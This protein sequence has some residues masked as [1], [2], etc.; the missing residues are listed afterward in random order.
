MFRSVW[1]TALVS[2][3]GQHAR[4]EPLSTSVSCFICE[5]LLVNFVNCVIL[6]V[7]RWTLDPHTCVC[8]VLVG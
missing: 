7:Q 3:T 5:L 6:S 8:R 4:F 2:P 1:T